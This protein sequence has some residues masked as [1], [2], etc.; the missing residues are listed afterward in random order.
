MS[1]QRHT[2]QE[3]H[4]VQIRTSFGPV[5]SSAA[6]TKD[7]VVRSEERAEGSRANRVHSAGLEINQDST[8]NILLRRDFVIVD[9]NSFELKVVVPLVD[10]IGADTMFVGHGL[11]ELGTYSK[12][13]RNHKYRRRR[14]IAIAIAH[15]FGYHTVEVEKIS[16]EHRC[17]GSL[18]V[19]ENVVAYLAGLKVND[20]PHSRILRESGTEFN[21]EF[22]K[23]RDGDAGNAPRRRSSF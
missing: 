5:V 18:A 22:K 9:V 21:K 15:R 14:G 4:V 8:G 3:S 20:F 2:R 1:R 11:P 13:G 16:M 6:L 23:K 19:A 7:E 10:T 12:G 17:A